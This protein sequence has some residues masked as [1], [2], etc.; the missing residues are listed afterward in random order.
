M[1]PSVFIVPAPFRMASVNTGPPLL[2][3]FIYQY[4]FLTL[5]ALFPHYGEV[6]SDPERQFKTCTSL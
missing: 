6:C 2:N 4:G 5:M 3:A 1:F